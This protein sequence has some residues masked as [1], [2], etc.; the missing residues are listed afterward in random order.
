[1][2]SR[3]VFVKD[4]IGHIDLSGTTP[5]I[6]QAND[7]TPSAEV[8]HAAQARKEDGRLCEP[9]TLVGRDAFL[10]RQKN[11]WKRGDGSMAEDGKSD[12]TELDENGVARPDQATTGI[13][14]LAEQKPRGRAAFMHRQSESWRQRGEA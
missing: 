12:S 6:V 2:S 10:Q 1:M 8:D 7:R 11:E 9:S 4:V 13:A 3:T 5:K 14:A